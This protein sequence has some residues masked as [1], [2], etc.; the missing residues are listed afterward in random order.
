MFKTLSRVNSKGLFAPSLANPNQYIWNM[1]KL[2]KLVLF[3]TWL[4]FYYVEQSLEA[5]NI[6]TACVKLNTGK[7]A[8]TLVWAI[9]SG[10]SIETGSL[11]H[12]F[13][14]AL[15]SNSEHWTWTLEFMLQGSP[16]IHAM[17]LILHN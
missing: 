3:S 6:P 9:H 13:E 14:N 11:Q 10:A 12:F 8:P 15:V 5:A 4:G 2:R 17:L 7:I 1:Q 16:K